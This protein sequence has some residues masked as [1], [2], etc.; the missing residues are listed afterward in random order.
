MSVSPNQINIIELAF[1]ADIEKKPA[2]G[3]AYLPALPTTLTCRLMKQPMVQMAA[4]RSFS[5]MRDNP[6]TIN[7]SGVYHL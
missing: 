6:K 1:P 3:N 5:D 2:S 4:V 7:C